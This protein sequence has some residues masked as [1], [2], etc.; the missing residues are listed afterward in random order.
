MAVP[1]FSRCSF[2]MYRGIWFGSFGFLIPFAEL[3]LS[4]LSSKSQLQNV[5]IFYSVGDSER[6]FPSSP[7]FPSCHAESPESFL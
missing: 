6:Y 2:L 7:V 5:A 3:V 1:I 4:D